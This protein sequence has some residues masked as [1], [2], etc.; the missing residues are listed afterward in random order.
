MVFVFGEKDMFPFIIER[1]YEGWSS[2]PSFFRSTFETR[3][4]IPLELD[5]RYFNVAGIH[6]DLLN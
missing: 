2:D 6:S 3:N 5:N 4:L 1:V